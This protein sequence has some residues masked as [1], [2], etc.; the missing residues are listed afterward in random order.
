[1]SAVDSALLSLEQGIKLEELGERSNSIGKLNDAAT[2]YVEACRLLKSYVRNNNT[3]CSASKR[4][5]LEEKIDHYENRSRV[6]MRKVHAHSISDEP[7]IIPIEAT[8]IEAI[9]LPPRGGTMIQT[10]SL[11]SLRP[12]PVA[13]AVVESEDQNHVYD[14]GVN[15]NEPS[16]IYAS[17]KRKCAQADVLI[18]EAIALD[19]RHTK[20]REAIEK[21]KQGA[22]LSLEAIKLTELLGGKSLDTKDD[23]MKRFRDYLKE[24]LVKILDRME[25]LQ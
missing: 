14:E 16:T 13:H 25:Q 9:P 15:D 7:A 12:L 4:Q 8:L 1:M 21:Y 19:N 6:L 22:A 10:D 5:F 18:K 20:T 24:K 2:H 11:R 23:E 17:L 3:Q